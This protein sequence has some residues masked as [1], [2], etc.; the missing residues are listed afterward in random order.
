MIAI[1]VVL[2]FFVMALY[3][4]V[5]IYEESRIFVEFKQ[6]RILAFLVML[7][8]FGPFIII[9]GSALLP[10][11]LSFIAASYCYIPALILALIIER[12]FEKTGTDRVAK[13]Q[14]IVSKAF[15]TALAGL[16]YVIISLLTSVSLVIISRV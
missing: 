14:G 6:P 2:F 11:P 4:A 15:L 1:A 7:F 12:A 8:P 13:A 3:I 16:A 10:F 9:F 5:K